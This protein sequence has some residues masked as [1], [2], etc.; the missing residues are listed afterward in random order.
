MQW[1]SQMIAC[2]RHTHTRKYV[3]VIHRYCVVEI[4]YTLIH[5]NTSHS[6]IE[7]VVV[8]RWGMVHSHDV[9]YEWM[10][11]VV[12]RWGMVHTH[13]REYVTVIHSVMHNY[14]CSEWVRWLPRLRVND[15]LIHVSKSQL[16]IVCVII[17]Y[18][19]NESDDCV[20]QRHTATSPQGYVLLPT[21]VFVWVTQFIYMWW[22]VTRLIDVCDMTMY[23]TSSLCGECLIHMCDNSFTCGTWLIHICDTTH[24]YVGHDSFTRGTWLIHTWD[25][26]HSY[27]GH[28]SFICVAWLIHMYYMGHS[29]VLHGSFTCATWLI[30]MYYM[31]HSYMLHGSL[32]CLSPGVFLPTTHSSK[33]KRVRC[34]LRQ[35][36]RRWVRLRGDA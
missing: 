31:A 24:S 8:C 34:G 12:C 21:L 32:T 6:F 3:T 19:V 15:T 28:D 35:Y 11:R 13:T 16:F 25:M 26:T 22:C 10:W 33:R 4:W 17:V 2:Q 20:C 7:C 36:G 23:H 29:C 18:I 1:M 9:F 14:W 30:H 5:V 27:A